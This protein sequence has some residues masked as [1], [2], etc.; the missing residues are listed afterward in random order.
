MLPLR[1]H[2][3]GHQPGTQTGTGSVQQLG[4][5]L[6]NIGRMGPGRAGYYLTAVAKQDGVEGYYLARGR[7]PAAGSAPGRRSSGCRVR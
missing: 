4:R 2:P 7:N 6:L 1:P 5:A 3:A